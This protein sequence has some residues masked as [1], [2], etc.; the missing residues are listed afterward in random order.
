MDSNRIGNILLVV[1]LGPLGV[2]RFVNGEVGMG[3]L[4]LCTFGLFGIGWIIDIFRA[5]AGED[6]T[7]GTHGS[8]MMSSADR[9]AIR[10]GEVLN[11][12][13]TALNMASDEFCCYVDNGSTIE[14][15]E[16]VTG[17]EY[18]GTHHNTRMWKDFSVGASK[19]E[20][21]VIREKRRKVYP[22]ILYLTNKRLVYTSPD[23]SIDRPLLAIA[24]VIPSGNG[25]RIQAGPQLFDIK[26]NTA[27]EFMMTFNRVKNGDFA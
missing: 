5:V 13:G 16:I 17:S 26:T 23:M 14:E 22:G 21:R 11:I 4:Y 9:A 6:F 20:S 3:I 10:R 25:L 27:Q 8:S 1:F 7:S 15:Q 12:Q 18:R 24:S 19:G 2:H